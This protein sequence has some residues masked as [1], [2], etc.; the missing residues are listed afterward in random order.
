[1]LKKIILQF[2]FIIV[3]I[4]SIAQNGKTATKSSFLIRLKNNHYIKIQVCNTSTIRIRQRKDS[5]FKESLL[6][7]YEILKTDW[8]E[9]TFKRIDSARNITITT[10]RVIFQFNFMDGSFLLKNIDGKVLIN[11]INIALQIENNQFREL[12]KSVSSY[13][14]DEKITDNIIG[15]TIT[16]NT[17]KNL[18]YRDDAINNYRQADVLSLSL[19]QN[20][21]LYGMGAASR[22]HLQH[23]NEVLRIWAKYQKAESPS[24]FLMSTKGWGILNNTTKKH[25][26]DIG[27]FHKDSLHIIQNSQEADFYLFAGKNMLDILDQY[28]ALTGRPYLL[29]KWAYGLTFNSNTME[30]QFKVLENAL[31]F[32]QE[33]IPCDIYCLEPQWMKKYY[34]F[35][36]KQDWDDKKFAGDLPW[37]W[38][39]ADTRRTLFIQR[40]KDMGFKLA[41]W[42]CIDQDLSVE[43]E[44]RIAKRDNKSLSGLEHWFPHLT[45]FIDQGVQGFK[46]DPARVLDEHPNRKY[47]NGHTDEDMH[48]LTQV[49][50]PKQ[51]STMFK[52]HTGQRSFQHYCGG[53]T[54]IQ[55]WSAATTGDIGGTKKSL[56]D[57]MNQAMT[58]HM[59]L[60]CDMLEQVYPLAEG[61]H[62]GLFLPWAQLDSWAYVFHPWFF[63]P[64][65]KEM[66]KYYAQ[67]R[68]S[69]NPYIY[70]TALNGAL[71]GIPIGRPLPLIYPDDLAVVDNTSEYMFGD[72]LLVGFFTNQ[73][74]LPQGKW[75]DY[76][77][78]KI[79]RGGQTISYS[80]PE[81][82]GGPLF[83]KS[84]AIIPYQNV[85]PFISITSP[86]SL[87]IKFYPEGNSSYNLLEDDGKSYDYE[88]GKYSS[89][90]FN[91]NELTN[92]VEITIGVPKGS[93]TGQSN[94]RVYK[95]EVFLP[96]PTSITIG[97][98]IFPA[99]H[100]KYSNGAIN[101]FVNAPGLQDKKITIWR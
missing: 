11:K 41:L 74:Y 1:M 44:D 69:L 82:R 21:R 12:K 27:N 75:I 13:M 61:I 97:G 86:D 17:N 51:L 50:S 14:P 30:D 16:N 79:Y 36:S 39:N 66:F 95:L 99:T 98:K 94:K 81:N 83:I 67:L 91:C 80:I 18:A 29:P 71:T 60:S 22:Q 3:Y 63:K 38:D 56:F 28:T 68:Y 96:K 20:E 85:A 35:S 9:V 8:D 47:Y 19:D 45:K 5:I 23:R 15:D 90:L 31:H 48:N 73:I 84:G 6:E 76:W 33:K 24:P 25:Y 58:G 40:L 26:F 59:N 87:I 93:F 78:G 52:N 89:T 43:E 101:L 7:R 32:R 2:F 57:I 64:S 54:G 62:L 100:W 77:T 34:D 37:T 53:Y 72:N 46:L 70:S 92:K 55:H 49:L 10:D 88:V 65:D 4:S 42:L